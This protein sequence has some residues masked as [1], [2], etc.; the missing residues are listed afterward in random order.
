VT[1][2]SIPQRAS[3]V[4]S[5]VIDGEAVLVHPGQGKVR[6]LNPVGARLWELADGTLT[7]GG[8]AQVI[9]VEYD[10]DLA[11]AENDALAFCRD[12]AERGVLTVTL[13]PAAH[14]P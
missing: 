4:I 9:A 5:R 3:A 1:L 6:V 14:Q 13:R 8:I 2:D 12:L 10:V 11:Q 7:V